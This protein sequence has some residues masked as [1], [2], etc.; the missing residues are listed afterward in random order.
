MNEQTRTELLALVA[1]AARSTS[2]TGRAQILDELALRIHNEPGDS[3]PA[4]T[5]HDF[6]EYQ[7]RGGRSDLDQW[8]A[9]YKDDYR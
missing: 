8:W 6:T 2:H 9:R 1:N 7:R 3:M 5:F 4:A